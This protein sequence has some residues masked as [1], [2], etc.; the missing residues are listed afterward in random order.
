MKRFISFFTVLIFLFSVS[1]TS[2]AEDL[3]V[4]SLGETG[5]IEETYKEIT[6]KVTINTK[7][8]KD[9]IITI[10]TGEEPNKTLTKISYSK[11]TFAVKDTDFS[12]VEL[13]DTAVDTIIT[14]Y[15]LN[16]NIKKESIEP[17]AVVVNV[18]DKAIYS[19]YGDFDDK[20]ISSNN[21]YELI[22]SKDTVIKT[23]AGEKKEKEAV[24]K[25]TLLVF[26]DKMTKSIPAQ[27][28]TRYIYIMPDKKIKNTVINDLKKISLKGVDYELKSHLKV[29]ES[30]KTMIPLREIAEQLKYIVGWDN[31]TKSATVK[32]ENKSITFKIG[33]KDYYN[34]NGDKTVVEVPT[35]LIDGK[36]YIPLE[37]LNVSFGLKYSINSLGKLEVTE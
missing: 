21:I 9:G 13:K 8:E 26:F 14:V 22:I 27:A 12:K 18:S 10:S 3:A 37:T 15:Y 2:F 20:Y 11:D 6:G 5:H 7:S 23:S 31:E 4:T 24:A 16:S 30:G 34:F 32:N 35:S 36:T 17:V 19:M 25:K 29:S 28:S 1:I 33:S